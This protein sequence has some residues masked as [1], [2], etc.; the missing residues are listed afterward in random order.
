MRDCAFDIP[1]GR[2]WAGLPKPLNRRLL[3]ESACAR[4]VWAACALWAC[5]LAGAQ[6]SYTGQA[7]APVA[8]QA[9]LGAAEL[10]ARY[11]G[12]EL[13]HYQ[14]YQPGKTRY[15][16]DRYLWAVSPEFAQ[17][18]CMPPELV[19]TELKGAQAV[20]FKLVPGG[21]GE[22][23]G[24]GGQ[25]EKCAQGV[26]LRFEIYIS[27]EVKLPVKNEVDFTAPRHRTSSYSLIGHSQRLQAIFDEQARSGQ[28]PKRTLDRFETSA[29]GLSGIQGNQVVWPITTLYLDE[30]RGKLYDGSLDFIALQGS[31]GMFRN[32]RMLKEG[33]QEFVIEMTKPG[34]KGK[35]DGLLIDQFAHV[36]HLPRAFSAQVQAMDLGDGDDW[37]A[38]AREALQGSALKR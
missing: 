16:K 7:P 3:C 1:P 11:Q 26:D 33:I 19:S 17:K 4:W 13:G 38:L 6:E 37:G 29:F 5:G 21:F 34:H 31:S 36:I 18:F 25:V 2:C 27:R 15:A 12:C 14:G 8:G 22:N 32:R 20:A 24:W 10:K 9:V 23:C 30:Y 35:V 28:V